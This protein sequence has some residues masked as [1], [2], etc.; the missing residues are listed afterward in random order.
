[1][2]PTAVRLRRRLAFLPVIGKRARR[3]ARG[4]PDG[5]HV[6]T[7]VGVFR[8]NGEPFADFAHYRPRRPSLA[9]EPIPSRNSAPNATRLAPWFLR[10][11]PRRGIVLLPPNSHASRIAPPIAFPISVENIDRRNIRRVGCRKRTPDF[12]G[13]ARNPR[14]ILLVGR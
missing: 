13:R 10:L 9:R 5:I 12:Y 7:Y 2:F 8:P 14:K 3:I 6:A 4:N 11:G 1:M